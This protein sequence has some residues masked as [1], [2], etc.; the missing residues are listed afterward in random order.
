MDPARSNT[1]ACDG[2]PNLVYV[3]NAKVTTVTHAG[4][5]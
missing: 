5:P 2:I 4:M 1:Q 3:A